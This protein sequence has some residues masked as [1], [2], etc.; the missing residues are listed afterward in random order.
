MIDTIQ[1]CLK[2]LGEDEKIERVIV[3]VVLVGGQVLTME[4]P[5]EEQ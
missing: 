4:S 5:T 2:T 3:T 1:N